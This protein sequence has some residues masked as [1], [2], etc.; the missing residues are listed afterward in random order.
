MRS[1]RDALTKIFI[2][3][4]VIIIVL[5]DIRWILT[6][7][8]VRGLIFN[9]TVLFALIGL[10]TLALF[11]T[12]K[13]Y[14]SR[15]AGLLQK[16][17][18]QIKTIGKNEVDIFQALNITAAKLL[19]GKC[20]LFQSNSKLRA[21]GVI[22]LTGRPRIPGAEIGDEGRLDR[23]EYLTAFYK[24][25]DFFLGLQKN[26]IPCIYTILLKPLSLKSKSVQLE[27]RKI[28]TDISKLQN[29]ATGPRASNERVI[30]EKKS[31]LQRL[32]TGGKYGFFQTEI[33]LMTWVDG[34]ESSLEGLLSILE[35]NINSVLTAISTVFPEMEAV[36]LENRELLEAVGNFF[37][38][39][40]NLSAC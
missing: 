40:P 8:W 26:G 33:L 16:A 4:I 9:E 30:N 31:E 5:L 7:P 29:S 35:G 28:E 27:V 2:A 14:S 18:F 23:L 20:M 15:F 25:R 17:K 3:A 39:Y 19:R 37:C 32:C 36:K 6:D 12:F 34:E 38:P 24:L 11:V 1:F 13:R 10:L 22:R 21:M